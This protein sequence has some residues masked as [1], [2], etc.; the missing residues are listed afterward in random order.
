M[1]AADKKAPGTFSAT[2]LLDPFFCA[3]LKREADSFT[4]GIRQ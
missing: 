2:N 3:I 4:D 1:N